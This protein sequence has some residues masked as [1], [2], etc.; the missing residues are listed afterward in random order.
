[1]KYT[2][3]ELLQKQETI[4]SQTIEAINDGIITCSCGKRC[5]IRFFFKCLYC[6]EIFCFVC[7]EAHFGQTVKE[8]NEKKN[9]TATI[10]NL[11]MP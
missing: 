10:F 4:K 11:F 8:Y 5:H 7:A 6:R 9:N 1:M 2:E 3:E